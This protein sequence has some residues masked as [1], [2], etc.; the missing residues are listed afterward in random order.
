M[1]RLEPDVKWTKAEAG[2]IPDALT[3]GVALLLDLARRQKLP[4]LAE[5]V[6]IRREGGFSGFDVL[7]FLLLYFASPKRTGLRRFWDVAGLHS[8]QLAALAGRTRLPS[9]ASISR[10]LDNVEFDL[11]RPVAPWLLAEMSGIDVVLRHPS[12]QAYD[13]RGEGWHLFHYDPTVHALRHRALPEGDDMPAARLR[14]ERIAAAG[15]PGRKRGDV[16][17]RRGT[18]QHAGSGAWLGCWLAPGNTAR[19]DGLEAAVD[20]TVATCARIEHPK[21]RAMLLLDGEYGWIPHYT[22]CRERGMPFLTRLTRPELL[23]DPVVR[24]RLEEAVWHFVPDSLSG[25]R[26][27]AID[28]G[29]VTIPPGKGTRRSDGSEYEP[30]DVRVV[31]S[32]FPRDGAPDHGRVVQG[33]QYELFVVDAPAEA[34]PAPAAVALFFSRAGQENRFAQEDREVGLDRIFSYGLAGQEL[35]VTVGLWVWNLRIARGYD[36]DSPP[37]FAPSQPAYTAEVDTRGAPPSARPASPREA[38]TTT[39]STNES[40]PPNPRIPALI[41]TKKPPETS[42]EDMSSSPAEPV[43]VARLLALIDWPPIL[44]RKPAWS[45]DAATGDLVCPDGRRLI[46]TTV[47]RTEH[48]AGRTSIIF[49]R[50]V[51]G[52]DT[53]PSDRRCLRS[54]HPRSAKHLEISVPTNVAAQLRQQLRSRRDQPIAT[55]PRQ[56]TARPPREVL[57]RFTISP[58]PD[59]P[60][61]LAVTQSL[62]LPAKARQIL[63]ATARGAS[64]LIDVRAP[65]D[66]VVQPRLLARSDGDRQHRRLTWRQQLARYALP[67]DVPVGVEIR[68]GDGLRRWLGAPEV[69]VRRRA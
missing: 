34:W 64:V 1:A 66:P 9:P 22:A 60:G 18:L 48:S 11:L 16:Q 6:R 50:P 46:L 32:R 41:P 19:A 69:A 57:P 55:L 4:A 53:C 5:R 25:P 3:E 14:S 44:A 52:C 67:A 33:W 31:V 54:K 45:R 28:L 39:A 68:G 24:R 35:A 56:E 37:P 58:A 17:V 43:D 21:E 40:V 62:F 27:S 7:L 8:R 59:A 63:N 13:A 65:S 30:V 20:V 2:R 61:P 38:P 26:R 10:A 42:I 12:V 36:L 51:G 29:I 15:Y 23:D 49:C 47:R